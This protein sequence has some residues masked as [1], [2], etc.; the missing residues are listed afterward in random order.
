MTF[1]SYFDPSE[2]NYDWDTFTLG[3]PVK[4]TPSAIKNVQAYRAWNF[5]SLTLL[6]SLK[7]PCELVL[8]R[9]KRTEHI[10]P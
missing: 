2:A 10:W 5:D 8:L 1:E 7:A 3:E 9:S 4:I 6:R